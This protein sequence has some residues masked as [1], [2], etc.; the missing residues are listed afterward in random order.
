VVWCG[1]VWCG[2]VWCGVVW[3][4][5]VWCGVVWCGVVRW[6]CSGWDRTGRD[7]IGVEGKSDAYLTSSFS[8]KRASARALFGLVNKEYTPLTVG[9]I[10]SVT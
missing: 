1:V 10:V 6:E 2:V 9:M 8:I 7:W 3:C 4:G 5:V